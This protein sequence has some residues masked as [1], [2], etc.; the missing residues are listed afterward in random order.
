MLIIRP[1]GGSN[2]HR[3]L[4][5]IPVYAEGDV[6]CSDNGVS[7]D[8]SSDL[9]ATVEDK[10]SSSNRH[11]LPNGVHSRRGLDSSLRRVDNYARVRENP[12][13]KVKKT[14]NP[15]AKVHS[16]DEEI[17]RDSSPRYIYYD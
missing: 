16:T 5:D 2:P 13:D 15:Y 14:E 12:Y 17:S 10:V 11:S 3:S 7:G 1:T 9:Y 6:P 4:P 8:T